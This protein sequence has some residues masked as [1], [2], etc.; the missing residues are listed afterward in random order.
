MSSPDIND[1]LD[2]LMGDVELQKRWELDP[3]QVAG[4]YALTP[5]QLAA[6]LDGDI[7]AL[8]GEGLAERHVQQMRVSW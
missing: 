6:L 2:A 7:D 4:D 3:E 8:I 5:R 1:L